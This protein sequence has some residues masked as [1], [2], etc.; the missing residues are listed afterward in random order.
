MTTAGCDWEAIDGFDSLADYRRFRNWIEG[1]I[2][3]GLVASVPVTKPYSGSTLWE[4][5]WFKCLS[6][7]KTWRLVGPDPPFRGLFKMVP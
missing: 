1:Q 4:E 7:E 6:D 3:S 2:T 5:H